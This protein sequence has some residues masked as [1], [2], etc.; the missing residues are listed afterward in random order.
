MSE[1]RTLYLPQSVLFH[2][3]ASH[4]EVVAQADGL[5]QHV[6]SSWTQE[7]ST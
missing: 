1:V 6:H 7:C 5:W 2:P 3:T 4:C